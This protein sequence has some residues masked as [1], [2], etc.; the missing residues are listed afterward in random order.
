M[1]T[2]HK[3][4]L[5]VIGVLVLIVA[6]FA[7]SYEIKTV[8]AE[9]QQ[10]AS[11]QVIAVKDQAIK[12]RDT[13]FTAW[14]ADKD[15]E[16]A[17]LQTAKQAT[18]VLAPIIV[19]QG[20]TAPTTVTKGDL[21]PE[22]AKTLP[23]ASNANFTLLSDNQM[24]KLGQRELSCQIT[25][26]GLKK[27]DLDKADMQAKIDALTKA[28]RQ[29]QEAGSVPRW[30]AGL[31]VARAGGNSGYTPMLF[32]DYRVQS[33]WGLFAG[34]ENKAVFAGVSVHFGSSPK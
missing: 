27:C 32:L 1:T 9:E 31:G 30:T 29:W 8:R 25:E 10:K 33:K 17:N 3:V 21:P 18:Q 24:V 13:I 26:G 4:Y 34:A 28:N 15:L 5:G 20:G 19:P 2:I 14:K 11:D 22:V 12:D 7:I 6:Y 23:G 16:I